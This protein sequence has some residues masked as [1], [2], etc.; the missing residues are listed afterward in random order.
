MALSM[1]DTRGERLLV[2]LV[3]GDLARDSAAS[4][5][6]AAIVVVVVN[7]DPGIIADARGFS[8]SCGGRGPD[9]TV[10]RRNTACAPGHPAR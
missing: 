3:D 9:I 5:A 1:L 4:V 2:D 8:R 7:L 6:T 10:A